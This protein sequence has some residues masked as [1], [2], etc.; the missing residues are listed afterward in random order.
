MYETPEME[1]I[2]MKMEKPLMDI[3]GEGAECCV[4]DTVDPVEN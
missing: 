1:E 2:K 4:T 3:S